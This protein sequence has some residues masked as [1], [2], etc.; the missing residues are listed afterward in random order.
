MCLCKKHTRLSPKTTTRLRLLP[1]T[2]REKMI[3]ITLVMCVVAPGRILKQF[4]SLQI[5]RAEVFFLSDL[6][7]EK[8][9]G[10][11]CV[12]FTSGHFV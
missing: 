6:N 3:L 4:F 2:L 1:K 8:M 12:S 7:H 11:M 9:I 10:K 5:S